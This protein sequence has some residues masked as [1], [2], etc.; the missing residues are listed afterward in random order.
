[1]LSERER[2][3][4]AIEV[5]AKYPGYQDVKRTQSMIGVTYTGGIEISIP[6]TGFSAWSGRVNT[7]VYL[8]SVKIPEGCIK[9]IAG[10]TLDNPRHVRRSRYL[11]LHEKKC[12]KIETLTIL[13]Y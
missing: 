8:S 12:G 5:S 2:A 6:C 11:L 13:S 9:K 10:V 3:E 7:C 4:K 1:M